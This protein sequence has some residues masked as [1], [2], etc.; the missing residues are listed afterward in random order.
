[1]RKRLI[2]FSESRIL[3][4]NARGGTLDVHV[5]R[6]QALGYSFK[7]SRTDFPEGTYCGLRL[8]S[9]KTKAGVTHYCCRCWIGRLNDTQY[10][11]I[12]TR[13]CLRAIG[14]SRRLHNPLRLTQP[15]ISWPQVGRVNTLRTD[16]S[17]GVTVLREKCHRRHLFARKHALQKLDQSKTGA[18]YHG[19]SLITALLRAL[20][21]FLYCSFQRTHQL[22]RYR[23]PHHF[24]G[25]TSL[26]QLLACYAQRPGIQ[27]SQV[28][29]ASHLGI[30]NETAHGLGSAIE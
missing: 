20:H 10:S 28:R 7:K 1:M 9:D 6:Q 23:H 17:L 2:A 11:T 25:T 22:S 3:H 8:C 19:G 5:S 15:C 14:Q 13:P 29:L 12:E 16:Q 4:Q 30:A 24:Q 21:V 26:V 27:R 18:L